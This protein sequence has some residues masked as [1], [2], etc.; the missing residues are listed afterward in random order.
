VLEVLQALLWAFH[1]AKSGACYPSYERIAEAA[2][3]ARR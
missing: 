2:H 1:N 3:V